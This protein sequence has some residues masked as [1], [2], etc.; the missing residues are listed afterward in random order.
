MSVDL[1]I[2]TDGPREPVRPGEFFDTTLPDAVADQYDNIAPGLRFLKPRPLTIEIDGEPWTLAWDDEQVTVNPGTIDGAAYVRMSAEQLHDIVDDQS[3]FMGLWTNGAL[4]QTN[5]HVGHLNNWWLVFRAALDARL[6]YTPGSVTFRDRDGD[7][8]DP[9][10]SFRPD[11]DRDEMRH[12]LEEVGYLHIR[13]L[14][15]EDEMAQ[16]SADMDA[17]APT[18]TPDDKRSWWAKTAD[19]ANRVVRMQGFD[20]HSPTT[21]DILA[22]RRY[23]DI[24]DIPGLGHQFG[25]K[26]TT[27]RIEALFKPIGIVEGISDIPWHKDCSLGRHSYD[28]CGVTVGISVTGA[29]DVSGQLHVIPG[30]HRALVWAGMLQPRLE[31]PDLPLPTETGDISVHLSCTQHMAQAP[32]ERERRVMYTGFSLPAADP[33]AAAEA[34]KRLGA[35]REQ[36]PLTVLSKHMAS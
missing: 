19:G 15:T 30:T 20:Q 34:R 32:T 3:T 11:D 25:V 17:A 7:P 9:R 35:V 4:E 22:D 33:V 21:M 31:L 12:F 29:D 2:R 16:V 6:I 13:G 8:L 23:L 24:G 1:R 18:Y 27:N 10:H 5:G 14:F 36:A 28:C 26:R